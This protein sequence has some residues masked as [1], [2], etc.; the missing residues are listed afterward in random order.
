MG[1]KMKPLLG[2]LGW[3]ASV[4]GASLG[5]A[6]QLIQPLC[7]T[8]TQQDASKPGQSRMD[9]LKTKKQQ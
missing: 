2:T 4:L 5:H 9:S 8:Y 1:A 3:R 7:A 6:T